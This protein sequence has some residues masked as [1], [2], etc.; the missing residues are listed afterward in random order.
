MMHKSKVPTYDC[1]LPGGWARLFALSQSCRETG[2]S[3]YPLFSWP[4]NDSLVL[5]PSLAQ[6]NF[7]HPLVPLLDPFLPV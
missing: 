5:K 4:W 1:L 6:L 7:G 3:I 2:I